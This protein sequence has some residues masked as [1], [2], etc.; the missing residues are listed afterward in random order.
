MR[1]YGNLRTGDMIMAD[2]GFVI[3]ESVASKGV[4]V[5]VAPC[6]ES[7]KLLAAVDM[8]KTRRIAEYGICI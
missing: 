3:Q 4:L 6:L 5:N 7:M 2:R 8:E 1:T